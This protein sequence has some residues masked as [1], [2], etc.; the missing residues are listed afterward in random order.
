M[1][2]FNIKNKNISKLNDVVKEYNNSYHTTIKMNQ[3]I[4]KIIHI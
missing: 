3:L 1:H 2:D 4:L